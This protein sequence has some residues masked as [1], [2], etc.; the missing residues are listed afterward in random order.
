MHP[1]HQHHP[2]RRVLAACLAVVCTVIVGLVAGTAARADPDGDAKRADRAVGRAAA[3]LEDATIRARNAAV[4]L[5]AAM[6]ALPGARQRVA[7][8]R[9]RVASAQV[10]ANTAR[11]R[12]DAAEAVYV[13]VQARFA[14]AQRRVA[15]ARARVDTVVSAAYKGSNFAAINIIVEATGP[16]DIMDRIGYVDQVMDSQQAEVD[17]FTAARREA[18]TAQ[19][20]AGPCGPRAN[21]GTIATPSRIRPSR[22]GSATAGRS[23]FAWR[24]FAP[25]PSPWSSSLST[26]GRRT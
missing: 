10:A 9:G 21:Q 20:Q 3:V 22:V 13:L 12:A 4:M 15:L 24:M 16:Q 18:R 25:S 17:E 6:S 11:R 8:T 26:A 2:P 19:D 23:A 5:A 7:E 1:R 14:L